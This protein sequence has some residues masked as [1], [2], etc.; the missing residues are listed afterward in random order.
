MS[1]SGEFTEQK[2]NLGIFPGFHGQT[3]LITVTPDAIIPSINEPIEASG[4]S[5][6]RRS[7]LFDARGRRQCVT[8]ETMT[9][10]EREEVQRMKRKD[11]AYKTALCDA[12]KKFGFCPY[13]E[14]CRFAHGDSELRLPAQ[15]RGKAHPKYKTQLCDKFSTFGHC[16]YGPRCQ[17]IHKLKKGLPLIQYERLLAA[18]QISP[19]REDEAHLPPVPQG[20]RGSGSSPARNRGDAARRLSFDRENPF[21]PRQKIPNAIYPKMEI[22]NIE[23]ACKYADDFVEKSATTR[24]RSMDFDDMRPVIDFSIGQM[25]RSASMHSLANRGMIGDIRSIPVT[26]P[27]DPTEVQVDNHVAPK[28]KKV[29]DLSLIKE[30]PEETQAQEGSPRT[31]RPKR[32]QWPEKANKMDTISEDDKEN[33]ESKQE[34]DNRTKETELLVQSCDE[35]LLA[36]GLYDHRYPDTPTDLLEQWKELRTH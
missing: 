16:P 25:G 26:Q 8:W 30:E 36:Q 13:G 33:N 1:R 31:T 4:G 7:D 18:G 19:E 34:K 32:N 10:E 2:Q 27:V 5:R 12:F 3:R 23:R 20:R 22:I 14:G 35:E 17:F 21:T 9:D 11:E 28:G 6:R 29:P 24:R 15:P